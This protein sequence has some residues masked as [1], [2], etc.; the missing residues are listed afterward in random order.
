MR[1]APP[2][3]FPWPRRADRY[4]V[5]VNPADPTPSSRRAWL[6]P[7]LAALLC[8]LLAACASDPS[9]A[10]PPAVPATT[11]ASPAARSLATAEKTFILGADISWVQQAEAGGGRGGPGRFNDHGTPQDILQILKAHG[12]NY[13]R[14]RLFVN[15]QNPGGYSSQGFCDLPHTIA[16]AKRIKAAG[17]GFLLDFHYSDNWADPQKQTKPLAWRQ[18]AL[19]EL[20][21]TVHDYTK[22]AIAQLK[23]AGVAPD[24]VQVGN[25]ITPG[26]LLNSTEARNG[27]PGQI[28]STQPEGSTHDWPT[29]GALLKAGIAGVREVTPE[30]IIMLH[31][32]INVNRANPGEWVSNAATR[33]WVDHA[34]AQGV[35]FDVLGLSCYTDWHGPPEGWAANF[36]QLV[37]QY[38]QLHFVA[39]EYSHGQVPRQAS[40]VIY[41]LPDR[42]GLG[43]FVWEA[44]QAKE[45]LFDRQGNTLPGLNDYDQMARDFVRR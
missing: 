16:F 24:M 39:A 1:S 27:Q 3:G 17:L 26:F 38:P 7:A 9:A 20:V 5:A 44:T 32:A 22:D 33:D 6:S 18:L 41:Q 14:L 34:L 43:S 42:K 31:L 35:R 25:E 23:A 21:Q 2:R 45:Q 29:L 11:A 28:V 13:I 40:E 37:K 15:P 12:F 8:L 36:G 4:A 19:P 30:A 10:P